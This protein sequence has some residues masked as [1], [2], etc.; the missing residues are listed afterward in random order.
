MRQVHLIL[1]LLALFCVG[2]GVSPQFA[3]AEPPTRDALTPQQAEWLEMLDAPQFRLRERASGELRRLGLAAVVPLE[4]AASSGASL[5]LALRSISILREMAV[6]AEPATRAAATKALVSLANQ[7]VTAASDQA[8]SALQFVESIDQD[9]AIDEVLEL[10]GGFS[11]G[12]IETGQPTLSHIIL[13]GDWR[14]EPEDMQLFTRMPHL[15]T[16]SLHGAKVNDNAAGLIAQLKNLK[17]LD[18]YG[19]DITEAGLEQIRI[20]LP[21]AEIDMRNGA[22]LGVGGSRSTVECRISY[23]RADSAAETAGIMANDVVVEFEGKP[24]DNFQT[25]TTLIATKRGGDQVTLVIDRNGERLTKPVTLDR[26]K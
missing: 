2:R 13:G 23:V 9:A 11:D 15:D 20:G 25:L 16:L 19:T 17:R 21:Q 6:D 26:W 8:A 12:T 24:V 22:F 1:V 7:K 18:L 4:K 3:T 5:E 10:G 14:G